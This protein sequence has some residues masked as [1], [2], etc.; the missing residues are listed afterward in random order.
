MNK[1]IRQRQ[2]HS[3]TRTNTQTPFARPSSS[4][5]SL[6]IIE[7]LAT[8]W[9]R[10]NWIDA[11]RLCQRFYSDKIQ[12]DR[13]TKAPR[14]GFCIYLCVSFPVYNTLS[15]SH[16]HNALALVLIL[17][18]RTHRSQSLYSPY[19]NIIAIK[20]P[21]MV[22]NKDII[23]CA[24]QFAHS[25]YYSIQSMWVSFF[26]ATSSLLLMLLLSLLRHSFFFLLSRSL[27]L[28][29]SFNFALVHR[30]AS[31]CHLAPAIGRQCDQTSSRIPRNFKFHP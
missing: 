4:T 18:Q 8:K 24:H 22:K 2:Q 30:F 13:W 7:K 11:W 16:T 19:E 3:H 23:R 20:L 9:M 21:T 12:N 27:S 14:V 28:I 5:F 17:A 10:Y 26:F 29:L 31:L 1:S 25:G 15:P 6:R